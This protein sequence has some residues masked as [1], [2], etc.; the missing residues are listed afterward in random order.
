MIYTY[1]D[2]HKKLVFRLFD[3][4]VDIKLASKW[5]YFRFPETDMLCFTKSKELYKGQ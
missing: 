1:M 5:Y 2:Y 4:G 3:T